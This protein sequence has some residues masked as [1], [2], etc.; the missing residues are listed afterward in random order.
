MPTQADSSR[1]RRRSASMQ[2]WRRCS[3]RRSSICVRS[4]RGAGIA[5]RL[6]SGQEQPRG[7]LPEDSIPRGSHTLGATGVVDMFDL[8]SD[9]SLAV[10][11]QMLEKCRR[12]PGWVSCVASTRQRG[13]RSTQVLITTALQERFDSIRFGSH[14]MRRLTMR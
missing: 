14:P 1:P 6:G 13:T 5:F 9:A 11:L 8:S 12:T 3:P 4:R 10:P 2:K 7:V